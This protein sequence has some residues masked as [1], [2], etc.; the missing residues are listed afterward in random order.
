[1]GSSRSK[2]QIS[3]SMNYSLDCSKCLSASNTAYWP[4]EAKVDRRTSDCERSLVGMLYSNREKAQMKTNK[5][6][7][8]I[9]LR[10]GRL[11]RKEMHAEVS[12]RQLGE[13]KGVR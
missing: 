13:Y 2:I 12:Q 6:C 10:D 8:N 9:K 11:Y 1:M 4:L 7:V 3:N 5:T